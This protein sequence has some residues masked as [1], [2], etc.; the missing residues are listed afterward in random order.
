MKLGIALTVIGL[1]GTVLLLSG[2]VDFGN[3]DIYARH[4]WLIAAGAVCFVIFLVGMYFLRKAWKKVGE[5][6]RRRW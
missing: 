6:R 1:A 4:P 2:A 5:E 3:A